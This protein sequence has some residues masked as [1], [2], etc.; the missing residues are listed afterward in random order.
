VKALGL[1][2]GDKF[3]LIEGTEQGLEFE[4]WDHTNN[5]VCKGFPDLST[6][7]MAFPTGITHD[8]E[9]FIIEHAPRPSDGLRAFVAT[10]K[11]GRTTHMVTGMAPSL[12]RAEEIIHESFGR[13]LVTSHR[14]IGVRWE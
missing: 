3:T 9:V 6:Y 1:C 14:Y 2:V 10:L 7:G 4:A 8:T 13:M 5:A 12:D 11:Q